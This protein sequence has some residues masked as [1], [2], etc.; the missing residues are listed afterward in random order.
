MAAPDF[1]RVFADPNRS[2]DAYFTVLVIRSGRQTAR[3]GLA[4]SKKHI[5]RAIDRNRLKRLVRE[6]FRLRR[7]QFIGL[8]LVV[9]ARPAA[10]RTDRSRLNSSLA[11]HL[12]R[13]ID[14][15]EP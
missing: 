6:N 5:R 13:L 10:A 3:L 11:R 2:A 12:S 9:M 14:K 7:K 8:D 4:I 1:K 15:S